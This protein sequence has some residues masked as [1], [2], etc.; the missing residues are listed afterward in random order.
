M[1]CYVMLCYKKYMMQLNFN[2]AM[3]IR[4]RMATFHDGVTLGE[5][6]VPA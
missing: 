5:P 4:K 1:L 2:D 3:D 6:S